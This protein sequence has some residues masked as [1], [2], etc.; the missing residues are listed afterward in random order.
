MSGMAGYDTGASYPTPGAA[1]YVGGYEGDPRHAGAGWTGGVQY[2]GHGQVP[3]QG[4]P[5]DR[6]SYYDNR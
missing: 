5:S 3:G 2:G 4:S 1:Q 6:Y